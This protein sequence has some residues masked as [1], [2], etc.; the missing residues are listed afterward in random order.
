[1]IETK[2]LNS[3]L[4]VKVA[5]LRCYENDANE[6]FAY[7]DLIQ[8][9]NVPTLRKVSEV[10]R[11]KYNDGVSEAS[12]VLTDQV[13]Q[14]YHKFDAIFAP[15]S[16][17]DILDPYKQHFLECYACLDISDRF[18]RGSDDIK[19]KDPETTSNHI[20]EDLEYSP[21]GDEPS[22]KDILMVDDSFS[23]GTT[24]DAHLRKLACAGTNLREFSIVVAVPLLIPD[25]SGQTSELKSAIRDVL[26]GKTRES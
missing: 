24:V 7:L 19:A 25:A 2:K 6:K 20:A 10:D 16:S 13:R 23:R 3:G 4:E 17:R 9:L 15:Q 26:S 22:F 18:S 1:M 5:Y 8:N 14:A 11:S 12:T 21:Q